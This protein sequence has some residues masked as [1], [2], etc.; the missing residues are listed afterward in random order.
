M[1][2][3]TCEDASSDSTT[4]SDVKKTG[5]RPSDLTGA[6]ARG[7]FMMRLCATMSTIFSHVLA[8]RL[9]LRARLFAQAHTHSV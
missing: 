6:V 8:F 5:L 4:D 2:P 9:F 3:F 7:Y 1:L